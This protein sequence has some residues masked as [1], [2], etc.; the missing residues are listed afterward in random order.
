MK[1]LSL[2]TFFLALCLSWGNAQVFNLT[3]SGTVTDINGGAAVPNHMVDIVLDSSNFLGFSYYNS[4]LTD[5]NGY[6]SDVI[7]VP[8]NV[9]QGTGRTSTRDCTPAGVST[10]TFTYTN[11]S[12]AVSNLD[13]Q[14]C[15]TPQGGCSAGYTATWIQGT[16]LVQFAD[17]SSPG[18]GTINSW[19]WSFGDGGT[20]T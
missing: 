2:F 5:A 16:T 4:V 13:H 18:N 3:V 7:V 8:F 17:Q 10:V 6:Y 1:K 12:S 19:L 15:T 11:S 9:S 20:S 14:I